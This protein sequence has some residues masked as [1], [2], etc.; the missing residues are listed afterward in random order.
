M[1]L[2]SSWNTKEFQVKS[3]PDIAQLISFLSV[4]IFLSFFVLFCSHFFHFLLPPFLLSFFHLLFLF[5]YLHLFA[6][7][8]YFCLHLLISLFLSFLLLSFFLYCIFPLFFSLQRPCKR[9]ECLLQKF[10]F[11]FTMKKTIWTLHERRE[12]SGFT[13]F[14]S[15]TFIVWG[16]TKPWKSPPK[17]RINCALIEI[18]WDK[19]CCHAFG[20]DLNFRSF[21]FHISGNRHWAPDNCKCS[22]VLPPPLELMMTSSSSYEFGLPQIKLAIAL[23]QNDTRYSRHT[24]LQLNVKWI[25]DCIKFLRSPLH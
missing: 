22:G 4:S 9:K 21:T 12:E 11:E 5:N 1:I 2:T 23:W 18:L 20:I 25:I 7:N 15:L 14:G 19:T 3:R 6:R 10:H 16:Q 8:W 24:K 17:N 13:V